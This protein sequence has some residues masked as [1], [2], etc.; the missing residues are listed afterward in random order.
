MFD[1]EK[2]YQNILKEIHQLN[3]QNILNNNDKIDDFSNKLSNVEKNLYNFSNKNYEKKINILF[4]ITGLNLFL[5]SISLLFILLLP[6]NQT[7]SKTNDNKENLISSQKKEN[8]LELKKEEIIVDEN[9]ENIK[10]IIKKDTPYFCL[11]EDKNYKIPFTVEIKGKL[12][13]DKFTFILKDDEKEKD[14]YIKK[15]NL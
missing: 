11:N 5:S 6:N 12:Y 2:K 3:R 4:G 14:C 9:F 1:D 8:F 15:E 10:P 13:K 7:I